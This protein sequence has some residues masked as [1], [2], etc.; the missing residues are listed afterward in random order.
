MDIPLKLF[1]LQSVNQQKT[2]QQNTIDGSE[3]RLTTQDGAKTTVNNGDFNYQLT[4]WC[5]R[6][7]FL[8]STNQQKI[9]ASGTGGASSNGPT[10]SNFL[11]GTD[12]SAGSGGRYRIDGLSNKLVVL[13]TWPK[14]NLEK[15]DWREIDTINV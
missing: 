9:Q 2:H 6:R 3:I 7:K 4:N 10:N 13:L 11:P 15:F 5:F 8:P 12:G 14:M 1:S